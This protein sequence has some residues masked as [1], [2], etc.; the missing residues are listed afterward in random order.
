MR[1][2]LLLGALLLGGCSEPPEAH[3]FIGATMGTRYSVI[4]PQLPTGHT[5]AQLEQAFDA[6][7][8]DV[9]DEM[10]TYIDDSMISTFNRS[11]SSDWYDVTPAFYEVTR[12][13]LTLSVLS[14][15]RYDITVA[16][17]V[18]L[19]GFGV[20]DSDDS[21][22]DVAAIEQARQ[23]MG[24]QRLELRASPPA[25][26]KQ[27]PEL[28]I[29]LSSIAK[30]HGVDVLADYL[31][32]LGVDDYL[33]DIGGEL[34]AGGQ[35]QRGDDWRIA[36][37]KPVSGERSVQRVVEVTGLGVATSGDYR[38]YFEK[39]GTRYSH[40]I[41]ASTGRPVEHRLASVT[42]L[43]DNAMIADGWA[44]MLMVLGEEAGFLLAEREGI[45][46]YFIFK[47][48]DEFETRET[49]AFSRLTEE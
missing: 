12:A 6:L 16:P 5:R 19:W 13:A 11:S 17:L 2:G 9:N 31:E 22:P 49:A 40:I 14:D 41:D 21:V 29:D 28:T 10:S 38:N 35:S 36:L 30:G 48:D 7:L 47:A 24:F 20:A 4:L 39:N 43:A 42:V 18:E 44:T 46:A 37:E 34:R 32:S 1:A 25:L 3:E 33:V 45:A 26:R 8:V 23:G 15:G 27:I